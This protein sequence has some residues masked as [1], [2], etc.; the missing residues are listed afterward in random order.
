[1]ECVI[2]GYMNPQNNSNFVDA[3]KNDSFDDVKCVFLKVLDMEHINKLKNI[4]KQ[5]DKDDKLIIP[6]YY[7]N[8]GGLLVKFVTKKIIK[9]MSSN[10]LKIPRNEWFNKKYRAKFGIRKYAFKSNDNYINGIRFDLKEFV[11]L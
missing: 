6:V 2:E 8:E 5:W 1:M 4:L 9:N 11:L 7:C 10:M 3:I